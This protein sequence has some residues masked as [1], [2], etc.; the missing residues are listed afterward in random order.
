M[1]RRWYLIQVDMPSTIEV[2]PDY[3]TNRRYWCVFLAKHNDDTAKSD[4]FSRWWPDWYRYSRCPTSKDIIYGPRIQVRP[5]VIPSSL[6]YIQWATLL[7]LHG[8]TSI[9][10]LGPFEFEAITLHNR[11]RQR[12]HR[13]HWD[14]LMESCFMHGI[15]PPSVGVLPPPRR[16]KPRQVTLKRKADTIA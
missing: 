1:R 15:L 2:N 4:E 13:S 5:N 7:P 14:Q 3:A 16:N 11:V 9:S 10:L 8:K 12:I 6:K